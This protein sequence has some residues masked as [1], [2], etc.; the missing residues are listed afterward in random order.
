MVPVAGSVRTPVMPANS[1]HHLTPDNVLPCGRF[2]CA[3]SRYRTFDT[4]KVFFQIRLK[5]VPR[6]QFLK[7]EAAVVFIGP[8]GSMPDPRRSGRFHTRTWTSD[9]AAGTGAAREA[10]ADSTRRSH[11]LCN[12]AA[13]QVSQARLLAYLHGM[14]ILLDD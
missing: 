2:A 12:I 3:P 13:R 6:R 4:L 11:L 5:G 14:D 1:F 8:P 9:R 7:F 10:I